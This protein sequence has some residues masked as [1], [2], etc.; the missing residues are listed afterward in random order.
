MDCSPPGSSLRGILQARVLEWLLFLSPGK[1]LDPG[2]EPRSPV[3]LTALAGG[4]FPTEHV[5][6]LGGCHS[7]SGG[8]LPDSGMNRVSY[9]SRISRR[10][11]Y[12]YLGSPRLGTI[13]TRL[14]WTGGNRGWGADRSAGH[15]P[16]TSVS[17]HPLVP[18]CI[19]LGLTRGEGSWALW[20]I[21]SQN[22][23]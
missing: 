22:C 18:T 4:F 11:L 15:K 6:G 17:L 14:P 5:C 2:I 10:A 8:D 16:G 12:Q 1:L 9:V 13:Y 23:V 7:S 3:S 19:G 21:F 20:V